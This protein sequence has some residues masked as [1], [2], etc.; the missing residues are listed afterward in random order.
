LLPGGE[1]PLTPLCCRPENTFFHLS[2][3]R[4]NATKLSIFAKN[5]VIAENKTWYKPM[6]AVI[7]YSVLHYNFPSLLHYNLLIIIT[8]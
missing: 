8:L 2:S 1:A 6:R 4:E 7:N 5:S 3:E